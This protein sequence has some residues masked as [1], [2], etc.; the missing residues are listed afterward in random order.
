MIEN[1]LIGKPLPDFVLVDLNEQPHHLADYRGRIVLLCFWSGE[2]DWVERMDGLLRPMLEG[3]GER[4][5]YLPVAANANESPAR[6]KATAEA[7]GIPTVLW[8]A[9][10]ELSVRLN[11]EITP[12]FFIVDESG[13]LRYEGAFDDINFR[14]REPTR[15][16]VQEVVDAL[17]AGRPVETDHAAPYGCAIVRFSNLVA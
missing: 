16:Y 7:R 12:D 11:A 4:V 2:C 8:D 13:I 17:L 10:S 6:L 5:V 1:P 3:W 15:C 9:N 14:Q